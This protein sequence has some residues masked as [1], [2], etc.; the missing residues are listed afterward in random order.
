MSLIKTYKHALFNYSLN[1]LCKITKHIVFIIN[2]I[3]FIIE[4]K[5]EMLIK[6]LILL[7][8]IS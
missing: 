6:F 1:Y 5:F 2:I 4:E 8:L 7:S 3:M